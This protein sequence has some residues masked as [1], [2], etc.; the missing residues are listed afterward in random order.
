ML[1]RE[2]IETAHAKDQLRLGRPVDDPAVLPV[3]CARTPR[4]SWR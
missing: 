4:H 1:T 3:S 2:Q